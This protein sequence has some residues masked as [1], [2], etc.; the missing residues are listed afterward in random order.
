MLTLEKVKKDIQKP[1]KGARLICY[2]GYYGFFRTYPYHIHEVTEDDCYV[3]L[4]CDKMP[5]IF[6]YD[7][8]RKH[9]TQR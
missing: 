8:L 3:V 6:T 5:V 1:V 4:D 2:E 9:F 7:K